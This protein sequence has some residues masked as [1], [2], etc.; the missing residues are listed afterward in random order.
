MLYTDKA[1]IVE[2]KYD[3]IK[4]DSIISGVIIATD[5]FDIFKND[6]KRELIKLYAEHSGII[7]LTDSDAA[8]FK[9]RSYIKSFVPGDKITNVY[10]PDIYGKERR[11]DKP[12]KEGKLGVEGIP[13]DIL[14]EALKKADAL[15]EAPQFA[16]ITIHD[17]YEN[18]LYG[19]R[20]SHIK[21]QQLLSY[22]D[23]PEHLSAKAL[24][25]VLN[26]G[27]K[28]EEFFKAIDKLNQ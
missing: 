7:I 24:V 14:T 22:L 9:I 19:G 18:G 20:D 1:I 16:D 13:K 12:S 10:I 4:L 21:R 28:T 3:K 5:G 26:S 17:L 23:L 15:S 8:G 2:G 27:I 6:E 25:E 11:K